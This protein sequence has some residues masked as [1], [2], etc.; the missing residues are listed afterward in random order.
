VCTILVT[1]DDGVAAPGLRA[2]L[3]AAR[4]L[5]GRIVVAA[6]G[7]NW[8]GCGSAT[9]NHARV[10]RV[11]ALGHRDGADWHRVGGT[12]CTV[13]QL[14]FAGAFGPAPDV[15]LSGVNDGPNIGIGT[16]HSGTVAAAMTGAC[17]GARAMAV[18]LDHG[19]WGNRTLDRS[20][21]RRWDGVVP[22]ARQAAER[23]LAGP[24]GT[25]LNVNVPNVA[26]D[27]VHGVR[28]TRLAPVEAVTIGRR[29]GRRSLIMAPALSPGGDLY[30]SDA[31]LADFASVTALAVYGKP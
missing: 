12:P 20:P 9:G 15:V 24:P 14:A 19:Q 1:N 2:L 31:L 22:V 6:P 3:E 28:D 7:R 25:L 26:P 21:D 17:L 30:D 23:L 11:E 16:F 27:R 4:P 18:S 8:S 5:G 10:G 13:V 29:D